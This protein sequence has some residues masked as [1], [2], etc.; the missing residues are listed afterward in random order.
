MVSDNSPCQSTALVN[1][2]HFYDERSTMDT[3]TAQI[4]N[5]RLAVHEWVSRYQNTSEEH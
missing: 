4:T 5:T 1:R 2:F 3:R